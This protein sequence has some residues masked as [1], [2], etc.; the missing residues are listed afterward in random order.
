MIFTKSSIVITDRFGVEKTLCAYRRFE[1]EAEREDSTD[2]AS[3]VLLHQAALEQ[4][5]N[6]TVIL[7]VD[8]TASECNVS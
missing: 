3:A 8:I 6:T 1:T 7:H 5:V 2:A 4:A